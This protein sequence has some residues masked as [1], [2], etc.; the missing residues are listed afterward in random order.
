MPFC[1]KESKDTKYLP[2]YNPVS[3]DW[4]KF[5]AYSFGLIAVFVLTGKDVEYQETDTLQ[6]YP[7]RSMP[8]SMLAGDE[9][10]ET[11][12]LQSYRF[13]RMPFLGECGELFSLRIIPH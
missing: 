4:V 10:Q 11:D 1:F 9:S 12:T 2:P 3:V 6:S 5:L 7:I 8:E 13:L